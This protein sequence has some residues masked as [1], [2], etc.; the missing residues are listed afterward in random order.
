MLLGVL[1]SPTFDWD[2]ANTG[3]V[4]IHGIETFEVEEAITAPDRIGFDVHDRGK[5]GIAGRTEAGRI[6]FVVHVVRNGAYLVVTARDLTP[7][8]KHT[9]QRRRRQ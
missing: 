1:V 4:A 8:E 7:R 3:H 6:L 5:K 2:V 9:F